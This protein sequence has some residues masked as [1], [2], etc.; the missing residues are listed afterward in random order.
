MQSFSSRPAADLTAWRRLARLADGMAGRH[1]AELLEDPRRGAALRRE[2]AGILFDFSR[3]KITP[4]VLDGL[5]AIAEERRWRGRV[6][7]LFSGATI[8]STEGQAALHTALR[9]P[10][11]AMPAAG[12]QV[13]A[14]REHLCAFAEAVRKGQ[15]RGCTGKA[16][17][18]LVHIGI[19]GSHLGPA[20]AVQALKGD[21]QLQI[22]FV[23]NVDGQAIADALAGADVDTTLF[24][25]VSKT[26][27]TLEARSNAAAARSWFLERTC[28]KEALAKH[29]FA[30]TANREAAGAFGLA[31]TNILPLWP[32]VG[33]RYSLW[34][35]V[36]L[37][38]ALHLGSSGFNALLAGAHALDRHFREAP[39]AAN[40]PLLSALID[41]W[42]YNFLGVGSQVILPYDHRLRLLPAYLQQLMMESNG[43]RTRHGGG[44]VGVHTIPPVWGGE[45]TNGQH[46]FHQQLHQGTRSFSADFILTGQGGH[47]LA[48]HHRWL[49]A[50]GLAQGQAMALGH[51]CEDPHRAAGGD[52]GA[53][54]ILL[55]RLDPFRFGALLAFY[56]HRVFCQGLLWGINSFDQWGVEFGKGLAQRIFRQLGGEAASRQDNATQAL[57]QH[58]QALDRKAKDDDAS[59][60]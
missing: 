41:I 20:L 17:R 22:H 21:G 38:V 1:L 31:P 45:G 43:K 39:A 7:M 42:N 60:Q 32:W 8:N 29:F 35:A 25:V 26:F 59:S 57:I 5:I 44:D 55:E 13:I 28:S 18:H 51:H 12:D 40:V 11:Q 50:N 46:S 16:F 27:T 6:E 34:S 4:E 23:A 15:R 56:E 10:A 52:H 49:L 3:H 36:G 24:L 2:V 37:P 58:L 9:A 47:G 33:G 53:T 14:V 54:T 48:E 30:V 19:G